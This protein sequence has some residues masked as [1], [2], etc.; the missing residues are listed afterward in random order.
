M[1]GATLFSVAMVALLLGSCAPS[2]KNVPCSNAGD[3]NE[4]PRFHYCVSARCVECLDDQGC[5]EGDTCTEG[6][7]LHPCKDGRDCP[8]DQLCVSGT[9]A[10][11]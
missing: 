3:C 8:K 1:Q 5:H 6:V 10:S 4:D 2:P 7:C 9:C 11:R